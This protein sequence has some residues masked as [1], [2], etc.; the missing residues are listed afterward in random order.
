MQLVK[1]VVFWLFSSLANLSPANEVPMTGPEFTSYVAEI[2]KKELGDV[3]VVP[4]S[5][6]RILI[7]TS[8]INIENLFNFCDTNRPRCAVF[9][10][11]FARTTKI[12]RDEVA[13]LSRESVRLS[14][15]SKS[16]VA[17]NRKAGDDIQSRDF[18]GDLAIVPV[19][20]R[21]YLLKVLSTKDSEVLGLNVQ[22]LYELGLANLRKELKPILE[23]T[24]IPESGRVG[25]LPRG[26][27]LPSRLLLH[28]SWAPLAKLMGGVLFVAAP[29]SDLLLYAGEDVDRALGAIRSEIKDEYDRSVTQRSL[30]LSTIVFRWRESGWEVVR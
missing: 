11:V 21:K 25:R 14:I 2:V 5:P 20:D 27:L 15:W 16:S 24:T 26:L 3:P 19:L 4:L 30:G 23:V 13:P 9:V 28:E 29:S 8:T 1:F 6:F 18:L 10:S 7:D 22:E 12:R 17:N